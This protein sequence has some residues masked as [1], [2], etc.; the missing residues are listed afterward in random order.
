MKDTLE[1]KTRDSKPGFIG[2]CI[3][4]LLETTAL[5]FLGKGL[6]LNDLVG[7]I[8]PS[9]KNFYLNFSLGSFSGFTNRYAASRF[10]FLLNLLPELYI[11][12]GEELSSN[13]KRIAIKTTVTYSGWAVGKLTKIISSKQNE[14]NTLYRKTERTSD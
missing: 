2:D 10:M 6:N 5:Y 9:T 7:K 1:K 12:P 4:I 11:H 3:K 13:I 14:R 8:G